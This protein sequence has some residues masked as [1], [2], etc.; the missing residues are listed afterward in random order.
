MTKIKIPCTGIVHHSVLDNVCKFEV[1]SY[2]TEKEDRFS[3]HTPS[4][5][6]ILLGNFA[7]DA[8]TSYM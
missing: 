7:N 1:Y 6:G 4:K 8:P 3:A 2:Y 5:T